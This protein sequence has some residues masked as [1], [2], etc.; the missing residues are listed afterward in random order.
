MKNKQLFSKQSIIILI[1]LICT[2]N[3]Y[4]QA[5]IET[6]LLL[7]YNF[8]ENAE[9]ISGNNNHGTIISP[10]VYPTND[11]TDNAKQAM[12]FNGMYE[13]GMINCPEDILNNLS[14]FSMSYWFKISNST[15]GMSLVGQDNLIETG[16]YTS[17]NRIITWHPESGSIGTEIIGS[18][19]EWQHFALSCDG[20]EMKIYLNG[21]LKHS[22]SGNFELSNT[23]L[24]PRIGGNVVNQNNDTW[25]R[26]AIDELRFYNRIL[27][28]DDI[29]LLSA[30]TA[31]TINITNV[32]D[33]SICAGDQITVDYNLIGTDIPEDNNLFLQLSDENGSFDKPIILAQQQGNASGTFSNINIPEYLSSS[34]NYAIRISSETPFYASNAYSETIHIKNASDGLSSLEKE[35]IL[36]YKFDGNALDETSHENHGTTYGGISYTSDRFGNE[37]A[38]IQLNGTNAYIDVPS[39]VL[40]DESPFTIATWIKPNAFNSWSRVM[41]FGIGQGNENITFALTNGTSGALYALIRRGTSTQYNVTGPVISLNEWSHVVFSFD[42]E[43]IRIYL[44]GVLSASTTS[45]TPR[46]VSRTTN[47]IGKSTVSGGNYTHAAYDDFMIFNRQLSDDEIQVLANDGLIFSNSPVCTGNSLFIDAADNLGANYYWE[48]PDNFVSN[49]KTNIISNVEPV[50]SGDYYL[51]ITNDGCVYEQAIQSITITDDA[52]QNSVSFSGLPEDSYIGAQNFILT[53][54]P[55]GGVFHGAGLQGNSFVPEQAGLGEHEIVYAYEN[56][57]GCV[58]TETQNISIHPGYN[59]SNQTITACAGGFFDSGSGNDNY[60]NDENYTIHFCSDNG[61][62]L[63]FYFSSMQ[64]AEGDTLWTYDGADTDAELIAIYVRHSNRDYIWSSGNCLTFRFKSDESNTASGWESQYWCM[65]NP[66][67]TDEITDMSTGLRTTCSGTFRDPGG[68]GD[69]PFNIVREQTFKSAE[70]NRLQLDF[71]MFD[72]N[73][74]NGGHWLRIYDGPSTAYP[75]IGSYSQWANPPAAGISSSGEYLTFRFESTVSVGVR[76]GWQANWSCPTPALPEIFIGDSQ[77]STCESVFYDQAG[78]ANDYAANQNESTLICAENGGLLSVSANYNETDINAGDTLKVYDGSTTDA[79]LLAI[80]VED[81]RIDNLI[82][83]GSCLLFVFTSDDNDE[84]KGWQTFVNC[85]EETPDQQYFNMS[86]GERFVCNAKFRDAGGGGNYPR[87]TWVQT[88]TSYNGERLRMTKNMF[89]VNGNNGGHPFKVY[90]GPDTDAPLIGTYTNFAN[91]PAVIQSTGESLCFEFN[92]T[93]TSAGTTAGWDF[94]ITCFSDEPMDVQWINSPICAGETIDIDFILNESVNPDNTFTAQ[95]SD[96]DG[97]FDSPVNIGTLNSDASGTIQAQ[98]PES[99]PAGSQYRIRIISSSP[100]MISQQSPNALL[101][102]PVPQAASITLSGTNEIC[103]G[104]DRMLNITPVD[105]IFYYWYENGNLVDENTSMITVNNAGAYTVQSENIC[106]LSASEDTISIIEIDTPNAPT[107]YTDDATDICSNESVMLY[108]DEISDVNYLWK[109]DNN[110]IGDNSNELTT[111]EAG[112]Y[113]LE[114]SNACGSISAVNQITI[115]IIAETPQAFTISLS[116][117]TQNCEGDTPVLSSTAQSG[118]DYQWLKDDIA[119][120]DNSNILNVT[121][122]GEYSLIIYNDC[123]T[124]ESSNSISIQFFDNPEN[125]E[126]SINGETSLCQGESTTLSIP[127]YPEATYYWYLDENVMSENSNEIIVTEAGNYSAMIETICGSSTSISDIEILVQ[128][129]VQAFSIIADGSTNICDGE[130]V[131]IST[132]PQENVNYQWYLNGSETGGDEAEL[133]ASETG[134][135]TLI[136]SNLCGQLQ[137]DNSIEIEVQNI[138]EIGNISSSNG[139]AFCMGDSTI[140]SIIEN[141]DYNYQWMHNQANIGTNHHTLIAFDAGS[142]SVSVSNQCGTVESEENLMLTVHELP[143]VS[144]LQDPDSI[145]YQQ[146]SQTL[147]NASPDGGIF[148]G[149]GVAGDVINTEAAGIGTHEI[150]YVYTDENACENSAV[151]Q[152]TILD[153]TSIKQNANVDFIIFP[154]PA[155]ERLQLFAPDEEIY[156]IK[157]LNSKGALVKQVDKIQLERNTAFTFEFGQITAGNYMLIISSS[158]KTKSYQIVIQ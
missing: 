71:D 14:E 25:L 106:G 37:N 19:D 146:G 151:S 13:N 157:L 7:H 1:S 6:G 97:S 34:E 153:C 12:L 23:S 48:G 137:S 5:D 93:N 127:N 123:G 46:L 141:E 109:K 17:P 147:Q 81:S 156:T 138:P 26:G 134:S 3:V 133:Q 58:S 154:N 66:E 87:G 70:G 50:N 89:D 28:Q 119:Y 121:E 49:E 20:T 77:T 125:F 117:E 94:D 22:I 32:S 56:Q 95:L 15:N 39:E 120:G 78:P 112:E 61:Q 64:L 55:E 16:Y 67:V 75:L 103:P 144:Y 105:G 91:P 40:F 30:A 113:E 85:I 86:T 68:S 129:P 2:F 9:D 59:M 54:T 131:Q 63:R 36:H 135:Y 118:C 52:S 83:T 79:Q 29:N 51:T 82:S 35:R 72:L 73:G 110:P 149:N 80:F 155:K 11:K 111:S 18:V 43:N 100:A 33:L 115:N 116:G 130:S 44:N 107:I 10:G 104:E 41:D 145:C 139:T 150:S 8:N 38:A 53:G 42:G 98:I 60:S 142:Y 114:I 76:P 74:N 47:Y 24:P 27:S 62:R 4:A 140:L 88:Y 31:I 158:T 45:A 143:D 96:A 99:T 92:S 84:G 122:S 128:N 57:S 148:I 124:V 108:T 101:I 90:D 126:I 69:Y 152:I 132:S 136:I 21:V 102:Y 65:E